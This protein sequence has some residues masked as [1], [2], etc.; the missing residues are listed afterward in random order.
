MTVCSRRLSGGPNP[1]TRRIKQHGTSVFN[2][3][4]LSSS[5]QRGRLGALAFFSTPA[6]SITAATE[7]PAARRQLRPGPERRPGG[8]QRGQQLDAKAAAGRRWMNSTPQ[9]QSGTC[10]HSRSS[11]FGSTFANTTSLPLSPTTTTAG[12]AP[13]LV[14]CIDMERGW[15]K[16]GGARTYGIE[17]EPVKL[18]ERGWLRVGGGG[19]GCVS[20]YRLFSLWYNC[21]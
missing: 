20:L 3:L 2:H 15:L 12:V 17:G 14:T 16:E 13:F 11:F 5:T 19:L 18:Q 7:G 10:S 4:P 8:E 21:N 6:D 9:D 1:V